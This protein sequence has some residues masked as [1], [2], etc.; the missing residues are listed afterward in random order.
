[1]EEFM[2]SKQRVP[3]PEKRR[4]RLSRRAFLRSSALA[5]AS[6]AVSLGFLG[7][8]KTLIQKV[9]GFRPPE[10]FQFVPSANRLLD[11]PE[12]FTAHAFSRT[13]E[14]MDDGLWVPGLHDGM[15]AY[16]GP[17]GK[18]LLV[19]NHE[20]QATHKDIG[21]F[22]WN[23]E[24][25]PRAAVDKFYDNGSGELPCLG[26]TT[27]LVYDTRTK[28]LE[29]HF[30]SLIGTIRNCAGGL[31][32]WNTWITCEENVQKAENTY[33]ADHGYNF[34][35]PVSAEISLAPA[36]PLK[37][38][39]RFNHEAVAVDPKTGIVYQTEDRG[40]G[41][42]YRFIPDKPGE[43][44]AGGKLQ[45]L[46][47]RDLKG[48]DTRNWRNRTQKMFWWTYNPIPVGEPLAVEWVDIENVESPNDDLRVQGVDDKAAAKF[49][50]GE[51]IWHGGDAERSEFYIA[52]TNGGI[53]Y[54][55]QIWKYMP[56]PDEGTSREEQ[57]PGTIQLFIE[58]NDSN[59]MENADNLTVT[60]WG[61]LIICE[62]GPNEEFLVG[63]TPEGHL[64]RFARNAGNMS[65][66]AGATFSPDGTTLFV[67]IQSPGITLA[68][69][70]PWHDIRQRPLS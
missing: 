50:R 53:V 13:G 29:K 41:L 20:L 10:P 62:D 33:Q 45:A 25:I 58:P 28:T 49:A 9:P 14:K 1:M 35:V 46:K 38:M 7:C 70:G 55:G 8:S 4:H 42:I 27:T 22:G 56:S 65:E 19:R 39:G 5:T 52:C 40:D 48:A 11:L 44:A 66:L 64:Y 57:N 3:A 21:P 24:H 51:G 43:L 63:V 68:I 6:A 18:T 30:L 31:T 32:P 26:G 69:T 36:V 2:A 34:E 67:N 54:K 61:D 60:P 23:N 47:L 17:N 16:P 37:A 59:L 15:A 12:G